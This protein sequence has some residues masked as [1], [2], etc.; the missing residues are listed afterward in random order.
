MQHSLQLHYTAS[1]QFPP[2]FFFKCEPLFCKNMKRTFLGHAMI[3]WKENGYRNSIRLR[4]ERSLCR[5]DA[6]ASQDLEDVTEPAIKVVCRREYAVMRVLSWCLL[7]MQTKC[8]QRRRD[9]G[10]LCNCWQGGLV[11]VAFLG[12]FD[13][14]LAVEIQK[15]D[16]ASQIPRGPSASL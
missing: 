15:C 12:E 13:F 6:A 5:F 4:A 8:T 16:S 9:P 2:I 7:S 1:I 3:S 11:S 14:S 10:R